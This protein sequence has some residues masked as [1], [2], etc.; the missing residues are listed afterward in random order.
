MKTYEQIQKE[1]QERIDKRVKQKDFRQSKTELN[2]NFSWAVNN[3]NASLTEEDKKNWAKAKNKIKR[4]FPWFIRLYREWAIE[5]IPLESIDRPKP[6]REDYVEAKKDA[7]AQQAK[8][9][10][11]ETLGE[12]EEVNTDLEEMN[13]TLPPEEIQ[14]PKDQADFYK[15]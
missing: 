8:Q 7:P 15:E 1:V 6:T 13:T 4:R 12:V 10:L 9:E 3:A 2:I 14:S 11:S 5:N